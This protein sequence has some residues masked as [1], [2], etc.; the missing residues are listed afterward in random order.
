MSLTETVTIHLNQ[1]ELE[2]SIEFDY[3][4]PEAATQD[5]PGDEGGFELIKLTHN[6]EKGEDHD[7]TALI[8]F[9]EEDIIGEILENK[10]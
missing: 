8:V 5:C 9:I 1:V 4:E 3:S 2:C 6:D 10:E 7:L